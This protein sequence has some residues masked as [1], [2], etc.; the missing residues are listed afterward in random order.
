[1]T[2]AKALTANRKQAP[3]ASRV[4]V[5]DWT[6]TAADLDAQGCGVIAGLLSAQ[7]CL[8]LAALYPDDHHF[9]SR[10]V[11]ARHGFGRGEYKYFAYPLPGLIADLRWAL[12]A[13]LSDVA[14]RWNDAMGIDIRYPDQ[15]AA[16][17]QRCHDARS[18]PPHAA[19]AAVCCRRLQ[20]FASGPL[21]R[22]RFPD[23]GCHS[24][25]RSG[26]GFHRRR[27]RADGATAAYAVASG[28]RASSSRRRCGLRCAS[29][30]GPG[31]PRVLSGQSTPRR[32]PHPIRPPQ[33]RWR[34][35][36]RCKVSRSSGISGDLLCRKDPFRERA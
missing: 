23:T 33:H 4:D 19:L 16:F 25:V 21:R 20:L 8:A 22:T 12:Y 26:Q 6:K 10:V 29:S 17:L 1:M 15:H 28:N 7:E 2:T 11:M 32:E 14:N 27:I 34:E 30:S 13:P 35:F 5:I 24:T 36:S 9:R 18:N 3:T 31:H